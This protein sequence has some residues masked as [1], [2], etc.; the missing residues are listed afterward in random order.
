MER[1]FVCIESRILCRKINYLPFLCSYGMLKKTIG[2]V[3]V[4]K[5][6]DRIYDKNELTF[7]LIWI[8]IYC[9]ANS[10]ANSAS[11]V[12]GIDSIFT[13]MVN[14]ILVTYLYLWIRKKG[15]LSYFGLC[16]SRIP[17]SKF[18]YY[19]P[20]A[21][22][23]ST[24]LWLGFGRNLPVL[25]TVCYILSMLCVGFL[26]EVI[27]RGFLFKALAKDNVKTAIVISSITFGIGHILNLFNGSGMQL[28]DNI[29][30]VVGAV[31]CGFLFVLIFHRGSSLLPCIIAHGVNNAVSVFANEAVMTV[32]IQL[33]LSAA[34]L[35]IVIAYTL[36]LHRTL[37][38][39]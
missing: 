1:N 35:A 12:V 15:L 6:L 13:C 18:L 8:G 10:L 21:L 5:W 9:L 28:L 34:I 19:L 14:G 27:F 24:N 36:V 16:K 22:F 4:D 26:E 2:G 38:K 11:A 17:A 7:A 39:E 29:C 32:Q 31:A 30:Q 23:A 20:L 3:A 25:D 33:L 37:P